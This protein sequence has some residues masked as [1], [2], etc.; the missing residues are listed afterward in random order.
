MTCAGVKSLVGWTAS[1][2]RRLQFLRPSGR[3]AVRAA[4][5]V[6]WVLGKE[7]EPVA[8]EAYWNVR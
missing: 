3:Q 1:L 2:F 4:F 8:P 6:D 5:R 7:R